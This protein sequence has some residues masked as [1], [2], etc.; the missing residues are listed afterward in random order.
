MSLPVP[1]ALPLLALLLAAYL[2]RLA[3]RKPPLPLPPGPKGIPFIGAIHAIPPP[4]KP[5]YLHWLQHKS[6]Y[7]PLSSLTVL[8]QPMIIVNSA[9][10]ATRLL[11]DRAAVYSGRPPFVFAGAMIGW[12][13]SLAMQQPDDTFKTYR[14]NIA[15]VASEGKRGQVFDRVQEEE[16]VRFLARLR[17]D[18]DDLFSHIAWQAGAV[19]LR[20]TYGYTPREGRDPLVDMVGQAMDEFGEVVVPG[21]FLV[22]VL[23][24]CT[25]FKQTARS[26]RAHLDRTVTIPYEFVKHQMANHVHNTS[27]LSEAI[28]DIGLD[29][30]M[31]STS[32]YI[33]GADTT[34]AAIMTFFLAMMLYPD[35]QA[36]AQAELDSVIPSSRLP[37]SSDKPHLPYITAL[38]K[39]TH[40]WH[41]V[42]PMGLAHATT[43]DDQVDGYR[44][45][46]GAVVLANTWWFTHDPDVYPEPMAFKPERHLGDEPCPDPRMYTFGFGRRVCPGRHV[47]DNAL[48]ITIAQVL[49]VF[50][51]APPVEGEE[52]KVENCAEE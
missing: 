37:V 49:S 47:A 19:I 26:M 13:K 28:K 2:L 38:L 48:F 46:K 17:R 25:R 5:A 3:A 27:Y 20:V 22:D 8:R 35:V 42:A 1:F 23:P 30:Q 36:R 41:P 51:I 52:P 6:Q 32:M 7:G 40:R 31:E 11:R 29:P 12:D 44:I 9:A 16:G 24:W 15:R 21:K 45:P 43:A 34:V 33:A 18:P 50:K 10:L 14:R 39:E 4:T